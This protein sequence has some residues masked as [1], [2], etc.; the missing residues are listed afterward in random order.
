[1]ESDG[2]RMNWIQLA[3]L[4]TPIITICGIAGWFWKRRIVPFMVDQMGGLMEQRVT[5]AI[6]KKELTFNGGGSVKDLVSEI[7]PNHEE[8]RGHWRELGARLAGIEA[9]EKWSAEVMTEAFAYAP[10]EQQE[11]VKRFIQKLPPPGEKTP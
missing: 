7:R 1:M 9:R 8:A 3:Q 6:V 11:A 10:A 5:N 4:V 2:E